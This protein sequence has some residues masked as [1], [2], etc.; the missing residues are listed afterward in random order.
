MVEHTYSSFQ[1]LMG[2]ATA[3]TIVM[4]VAV[5]CSLG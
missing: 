5:F 1:H 4:I 2:F 3:I